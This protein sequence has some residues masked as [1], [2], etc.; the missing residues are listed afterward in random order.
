MK[1][2]Y[3]APEMILMNPE[4]RDVILS[5]AVIQDDFES[6]DEGSYY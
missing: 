6:Q 4:K 5:S 2:N 1:E 3:K